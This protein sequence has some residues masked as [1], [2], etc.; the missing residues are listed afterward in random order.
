MNYANETLGTRLARLIG[1]LKDPAACAA[2]LDRLETAEETRT[3]QPR[4]PDSF[5]TA[6]ELHQATMFE[7]KP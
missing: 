7:E 5:P 3:I 2:T 6:G 4:N 1:N